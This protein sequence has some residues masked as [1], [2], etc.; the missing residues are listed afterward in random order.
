MKRGKYDVVVDDRD[1]N[2]RYDLEK[3]WHIGKIP[4]PKFLWVVDAVFHF[5]KAIL[6]LVVDDHLHQNAR[7]KPAHWKIHRW[8]IFKWLSCFLKHTHENEDTEDHLEYPDCKYL[9]EDVVQ[10]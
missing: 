3:A 7:D 4:E 1:E 5:D 9:L 6:N 10:C 2:A 8:N